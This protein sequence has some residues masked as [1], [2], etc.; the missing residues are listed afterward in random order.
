MEAELEALYEDDTFWQYQGNGLAIFVT[1]DTIQTYRLTYEVAEATEVSDRFYMK[2]LLPALN[3]K[4]AYVLAISQKSVKLYELTTAK[5]LDELEVKE[6]PKDFSDAVGVTLQRDRA[7]TGRLQGDEGERVLQTK[8]LRAVEKAVSSFIHDSRMPLILASTIQLQQIYRS[9][10]SYE[11]LV[12]QNYQG[13]VEGLTEPQL[14]E[15][16]VPIMDELRQARIQR[17]VEL[18]QQRVSQAR[19]LTGDLD[20]IAKAATH[21]QIS[22]LLVDADQVQYGTVNDD[23]LVSLATEK[24]AQSYD[25]MDEIADRVLANG[26]EVLAVRKAEQAPADLMPISAILRWAN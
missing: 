13:S 10:N 26:G 25:I 20:K 9:L 23:G 17:W 19:T 14:R 24:N 2:P 5:F 6:L 7:P 4:D 11:W 18:Y 16:V 21:G 22:H 1:P 8:F 3:P 12:E 15:L